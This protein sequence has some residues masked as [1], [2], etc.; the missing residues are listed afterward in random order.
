MFLNNMGDDR[1]QVLNGDLDTLFTSITMR[2]VHIHARTQVSLSFLSALR[3]LRGVHGIAVRVTSDPV[4][5]FPKTQAG[6]QPGVKSLLVNV[7]RRADGG[8][9]LVF[10]DSSPFQHMTEFVVV[11]CWR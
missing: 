3:A 5:V 9:E 1:S 2:V 8:E 4:R 7:L 11:V 6:R 10:P